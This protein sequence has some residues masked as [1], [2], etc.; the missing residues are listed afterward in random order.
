MM[1][2]A[3]L[4]TESKD[5]ESVSKS[6]NVDNVDMKSLKVNTSVSGNKIT[7]TVESNVLS[8]ILS[9]VDDL[10]RCQITSESLIENG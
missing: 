7:S 4:T 2:R 6:L 9:T 3:E 1:C 10:L 5:A 8:T